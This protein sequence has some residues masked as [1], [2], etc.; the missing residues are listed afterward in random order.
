MKNVKIA[1]YVILM[2]CLA[3]PFITMAQFSETREMVKSF[4]LLND[5][6]IE[7][8]NKYG[9]IDI[10][11]WEKDSARFEISIRVEEKKLSKLEESIRN[12]EFDIT[13]SEHY[14]IFRTEVEKNKSGLA[15]EFQRFKETLL[16]SDGNIQVDYTVWIPDSNRLKIENKFGDIFVGD[17]KGEVQIDLSN[18]NLK[19]NDFTQRLDLIL[20]FAD[21]TINTINTGRLDCNFSELYVK[22]AGSVRVLSKSTEFDFQEVGDINVDSRRD[23]FRIRKADLVDAQGS[24]SSFR[25][26]ELTDRVNIRAEYG[27]LEIENIAN[28]FGGIII[29]SKNTDVSLYFDRN[30]QF[31]YDFTYSRTEMSLSSQME[32]ETEDVSEDEKTMIEKGYFGEKSEETSKLNI[33]ADSG[34]ISIRTR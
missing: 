4:S 15:K 30:T 26:S 16:S 21:A 23:K 7:I 31:N 29:Q 32:K 6:Q 14:L 27:D 19:A 2:L 11:T 28:D 24:F 33:T 25:I 8:A 12:I 18:G 20:N 10:K 34:S 9:K 13:N 5:T 17:Y 1:G 3:A 22:E